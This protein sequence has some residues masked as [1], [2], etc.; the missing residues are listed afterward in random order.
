MSKISKKEKKQILDKLSIGMLLMFLAYAATLALILIAED[1]M[2]AQ[3]LMTHQGEIWFTIIA[4]LYL[5][6]IAVLVI[7]GIYLM[8]SVIK[9]LVY[10]TNRKARD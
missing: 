2:G 8:I 9:D 10:M 5:I 3:Y 4:M 6:A 1:M 7:L